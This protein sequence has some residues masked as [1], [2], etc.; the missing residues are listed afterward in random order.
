M[1]LLYSQ[2]GQLA[3]RLW[4]AAHFISNAIENKYKFYHLGFAEYFIYFNETLPEQL[5]KNCS[6]CEILDFESTSL[7]D[8]LL[9]KYANVSKVFGP[10]SKFQ[11]PFIKQIVLK[12]DGEE[13]NMAQMSFQTLAK[14]KILLLNGW[15][16]VDPDAV[17]RNSD[18]I[19]E[20]FK[21]NKNFLNNI[22]ILKSN[23]FPKYDQI[24]G[25]H[26][27]KGDYANFQGGS[28]FFSNAGYVNFI[29]QIMKMEMFKNKNLGFLLCSDE[30]IKMTDFKGINIIKSSG[31]FV[32]DLYALSCC[33]FIIGPKSTYSLW[34][35]F[36][37]K[38][39]LLH[40]L[41]KEMK[42]LEHQFKITH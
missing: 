24:V 17:T 32:E 35:S 19:R 20:I 2:Q 21:P 14:K 16:F 23:E 18:I 39:P 6:N 27:R 33:D 38:K 34:A 10:K 9:I 1:V 7:K 8:R 42:L 25:V 5:Q 15:L 37:G 4:Q 28:F 12:K 22:E 26:I 13:F 31:H 41:D 40:I 11:F 36:Y 3:N 30:E 29:K